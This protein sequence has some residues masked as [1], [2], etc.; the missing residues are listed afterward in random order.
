MNKQLGQAPQNYVPTHE[1]ERLSIKHQLYP[2]IAANIL[3][4]VEI[5]EVAE[6]DVIDFIE[7][8]TDG[9]ATKMQQ[10][11]QLISA[12]QKKPHLLVN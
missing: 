6:E 12:E 7:T 4:N 11:L 2:T 8:I 9:V 1:E 5:T 3:H 10:N